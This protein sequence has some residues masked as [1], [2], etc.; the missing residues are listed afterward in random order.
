MVN[1][2]VVR[3]KTTNVA[4]VLMSGLARGF[5]RA[6]RDAIGDV[7]LVQDS[8]VDQEKVRTGSDFNGVDSWRVKFDHHAG[9]I[10]VAGARRPP[11]IRRSRRVDLEP[12]ITR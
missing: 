11:P 6:L 7:L 5:R 4:C 9:S 3:A 10:V 8:M 2:S 1:T 12:S